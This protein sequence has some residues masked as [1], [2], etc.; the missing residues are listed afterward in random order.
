VKVALVSLA[1]ATCGALFLVSVR[2]QATVAVAA[3]SLQ[4]S[5]DR[6]VFPHVLLIAA[7]D[8]GWNDVGYQSIDLAGATPNIDAYADAGVKFSNFYGAQLCTPG[9]ASLM[10]GFLPHRTGASSGII[11]AQETTAL[12]SEFVLLPEFLRNAGYNTHMIGESSHTQMDYR[13]ESLV[14][15]KWHLG[16]Y[17]PKYLPTR[18]GFDT[19]FGYLGACASAARLN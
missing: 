11:H 4:E 12:S 3:P 5:L 9:R 14:V 7:D 6:H 17:E 1:L 10:T 18:R 2:H 15:G 16:F 13:E 8:L 19:Y